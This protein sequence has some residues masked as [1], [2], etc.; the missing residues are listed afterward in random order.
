[1]RCLL[2]FAQASLIATTFSAVAL[3]GSLL[4]LADLECRASSVLAS[5]GRRVCSRRRRSSTTMLD[6]APNCAGL[7]FLNKGTRRKFDSENG[8]DFTINC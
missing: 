2:P 1:M 4:S 8:W 7:Q 5:D 3:L 6:P